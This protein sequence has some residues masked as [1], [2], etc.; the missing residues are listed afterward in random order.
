ML[1]W[2]LEMLQIMLAQAWVKPTV[3]CGHCSES[4]WVQKLCTTVGDVHNDMMWWGM[5]ACSQLLNLMLLSYSV[6]GMPSSAWQVT[7]R[8][9]TNEGLVW[10]RI[11]YRH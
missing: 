10:C 8:R 3:Q 11:T 1:S 6:K 4:T 2:A 5:F 9:Q 7:S